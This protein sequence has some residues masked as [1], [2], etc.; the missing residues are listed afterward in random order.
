ML[1]ASRGWKPL[2]LA[3]VAVG[4]LLG[5][6]WSDIERQ[7]GTMLDVVVRTFHL[8]GVDLWIGAALWHNG[9]IVP[10]LARDDS[11][12]LRPVVQRFQRFVPLLV[13]AVLV[14]GGYQATTW[15]GTRLSVYLTTSIGQLVSLKLVFLLALVILIGVTHVQTPLTNP[16]Q[17][18]AMDDT[19][20]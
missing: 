13:G 7:G 15:L 17:S 18:Q 16:D 6:A 1:D 20:S 8:W 12:T 2:L 9:V 4:G 3:G 5:L 11:S 10:A 14:T 19:E